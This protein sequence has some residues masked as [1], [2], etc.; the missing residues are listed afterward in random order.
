MSFEHAARVSTLAQSF[1]LTHFSDYQ[2]EV[3][4]ATLAGQDSIVVQ[5]TGSGKS[6]C[7]QFPPVYQQKKAIVIAPTISLMEDQVT[8]LA[9]IGIKS[10]LLGSAQLDKTAE[11]VALASDSE[12]PIIFATP[13]WMSKPE[14]VEKVKQ[15]AEHNM[16]SLIAIDEAH[17]FHQWPEFRGAF[18]SLESLKLEFPSTPIMALTATAPPKVMDSMKKLVRDP[19]VKQSSVNRPNIYLDCEEIPLNV[20]KDDFAYFAMRVAEKVENRCA[21]IYTDFIN[22]VGRIVSALYELGIDSVAYTGEMD[23]K[24]RAESY[25]KWRGGDV[26]VMVATSA[27]GMGVNKSNIEHIIRYGV[28]ELGSGIGQSRKRWSKSNSNYILFNVRY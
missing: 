7:F 19:L 9:E 22:N 24:S 2:K 21:I 5:P 10:I 4:D 17:L 15:L 1:S 18:R 27:F 6:L 14:K 16:L 28:P 23:V 8:N 3:I 26:K 12:Y 11:D 25:F 13:E 20:N